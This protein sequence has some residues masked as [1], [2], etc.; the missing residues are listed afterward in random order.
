MM[1]AQQTI[2]GDLRDEMCSAEE[3]MRSALIPEYKQ[4][5]KKFEMLVKELQLLV[6]M[7]MGIV[8][9]N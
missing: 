1:A 4:A 2:L 3:H 5:S 6:G 9:Q 8:P 7:E